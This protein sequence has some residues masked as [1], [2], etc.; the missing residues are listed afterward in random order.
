M[1]LLSLLG[2]ALRSYDIGFKFPIRSE[3]KTHRLSEMILIDPI[4]ARDLI[5][6]ILIL[7]L[8]NIFPSSSIGESDRC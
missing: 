6:G 2:S 1:K 3:G 8:Y 5:G 7:L 4:A